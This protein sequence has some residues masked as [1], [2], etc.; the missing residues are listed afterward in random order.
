MNKEEIVS[1][2]K[3]AGQVGE[4]RTLTMTSIWQSRCCWKMLLLVPTRKLRVLSMSICCSGRYGWK[5]EPC[6]DSMR[7]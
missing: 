4:G 3:W 1:E 2:T 6:T 7:Q 5:K